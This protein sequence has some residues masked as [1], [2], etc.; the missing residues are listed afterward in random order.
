MPNYEFRCQ[1][2]QKQFLKSL[3]FGSK[4]LPAC[5]VCMGATKRLISPPMVHFKGSGFYKTDNAKSSAPATGAPKETSK[6]AAAPA[7]ASA[8]STPQ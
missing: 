7:P 1:T 5:P 3:P 6:P 8:P 2:C 4:D